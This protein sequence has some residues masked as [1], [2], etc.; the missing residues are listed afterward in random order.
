[1]IPKKQQ[2][3]VGDDGF[4]RTTHQDLR[5][6]KEPAAIYIQ[7]DGSLIVYY[8]GDENFPQGGE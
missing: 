1:M 8:F 5:K 2:V 7:D 6:H 3:P 4:R